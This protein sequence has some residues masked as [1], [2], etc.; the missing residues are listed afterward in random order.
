MRMTKQTVW[1]SRAR[2]RRRYILRNL[3][4]KQI[5]A[6]TYLIIAARE[7]NLFEIYRQSWFLNPALDTDDV[8]ILGIGYGYPDTIRCLEKLLRQRGII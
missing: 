7:P 1:G 8:E 6:D 4:E 2:L 3:Q 5:S